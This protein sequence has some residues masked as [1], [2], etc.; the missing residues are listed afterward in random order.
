MEDKKCCYEGVAHTRTAQR[1]PN[2]P[3]EA[4]VY[5]KATPR[6]ISKPLAYSGVPSS[7][8]IGH[9]H[10]GRRMK[11]GVLKRDSNNVHGEER[12]DLQREGLVLLKS[13]RRML[14]EGDEWT[15]ARRQSCEWQ[16][17]WLGIR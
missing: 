17:R 16:W 3:W 12:G 13:E 10:L 7:F 11:T 14:G 2:A 1:V 5:V 15:E 9:G 4:A 6:C 8:S